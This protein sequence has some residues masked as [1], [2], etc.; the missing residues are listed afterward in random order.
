MIFVTKAITAFGEN[1]KAVSVFLEVIWLSGSQNILDKALYA[2]QTWF[3]L[4]TCFLFSE[5]SHES[6]RDD[7]SEGESTQ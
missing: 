7:Q 4:S 2:C 3:E 5:S 1:F 6:S